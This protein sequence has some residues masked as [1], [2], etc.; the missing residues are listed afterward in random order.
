MEIRIAAANRGA[1]EFERCNARMVRVNTVQ[2]SDTFYCSVPFPSPRA[3]Q[4]SERR[5]GSRRS[6]EKSTGVLLAAWICYY[7]CWCW[8]VLPQE[9]IHSCGKVDVSVHGGEVEV[10]SSV[11]NHPRI[12]LAGKPRFFGS[13]TRAPDENRSVPAF[14]LCLLEIESLPEILQDFMVLRNLHTAFGRASR[15]LHTFSSSPKWAIFRGGSSPGFRVFHM[16]FQKFLY[17][18]VI[19]P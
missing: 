18:H 15:L 7:A 13:E 11:P 4:D 5:V 16:K 8:T 9:P 14:K 19:Y 1:L 12:A 6:G 3:K 17:C 10:H 2:F